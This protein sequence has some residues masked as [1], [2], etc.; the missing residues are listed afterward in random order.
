MKRFVIAALA[1]SALIAPAM[2]AD[3][4]PAPRPVYKAPPPPPP[5]WSWT[6]LYIGSNFGW[7]GSTSNNISN[8]GTDNGPAGL[9]A[10]LGVGAIPASVG[11]SHSNFL[12]GGQIGYNWQWTPNWVVGLE[13]DFAGIASPSTT[14]VTAFPGNATFVPVQTGFAR[15]LDDLGTVRARIGYLTS[16]SLLWYATGGLAYGETKLQTAFA[17]ATCAPPA[18]ISG[19]TDNWQAGWT[20]GAG[21]E[22]RFAPQWSV[23]AEY[24]YVDLGSIS[25]TIDYAYPPFNSSLT[26]TYNERDNIVRAGINY[27]FW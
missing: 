2:A 7:I 4:A 17:C 6:G 5:A 16:P 12:G 20:V 26:S 9:G 27:K 11:A 25:H 15:A 18:A 24:L 3:L 21:V 19:L 23:K 13:T 14:V 22:W 8:T 10:L 1:M